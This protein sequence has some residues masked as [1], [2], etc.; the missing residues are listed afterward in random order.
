MMR[1]SSFSPMIKLFYWLLQRASFPLA[2]I[3]FFNLFLKKYFFLIAQLV[4]NPPVTQETWVWSLGWEDP[5]EK[6]KPGESHGPYSPW[7]RTES[8]TTEQLSL[9]T[10][11]L[12]YLLGCVG[13]LVV[14]HGI[15]SCSLW[16][17]SGDMWD[18]VSQRV[19]WPRHP[20]LGAWNLSHWPT[21]E[22]TQLWF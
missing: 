14:A 8:D 13:V 10:I 9:K 4:K 7:G 18:L 11:Y 15:F 20:A 5:L 12:I 2:L 3:L 21:R 17:L 19:I 22:D 16:T 1:F 6:G